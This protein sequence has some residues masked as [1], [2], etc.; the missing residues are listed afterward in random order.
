ELHALDGSGRALVTALGA[1]FRDVKASFVSCL[2]VA[3]VIA[4]V[5][6]L[7][8]AQP[9]YQWVPSSTTV[10]QLLTV[11]G[12][13][14]AWSTRKLNQ[15]SSAARSADALRQKVAGA[16]ADNPPSDEEQALAREVEGI[17]ATI[18]KMNNEIAAAEQ[19]TAEAE[20]EIQRINAGGLVYDFL[21]ER[22][23]SNAYLAHVG[24][25]STIRPDFE[26]LG[27]LLADLKAQGTRPI[28]RIVLYIDDLDRC[29]P[30]KV[31][32]VLQAVHLLLA[33]DIF[34][35]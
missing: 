15:L 32:E 24:L 13:A 31:V 28:D 7:H 22:R 23:A 10:Y 1:S 21:T 34:N 3:A 19:R 30:E 8:K 17:D 14:L 25:I 4:A 9:K 35:V 29:E 11:G 20:A 2:F 5:V 27:T 33:F 16:W 18:Q 6:L 12:A 26:R